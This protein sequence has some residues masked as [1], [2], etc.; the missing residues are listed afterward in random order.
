MDTQTALSSLP[1]MQVKST[2][3]QPSWSRSVLFLHPLI[4]LKIYK[5]NLCGYGGVF[6]GGGGIHNNDAQRELMYCAKPE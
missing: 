6:L 1:R 3:L 4:S 5:E 2:L